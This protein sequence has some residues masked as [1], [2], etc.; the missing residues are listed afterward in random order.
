MNRIGWGVSPKYLDF[1]AVTSLA[2]I[3]FLN[4]LSFIVFLAYLNIG[5]VRELFHNNEAS[6]STSVLIAL[7]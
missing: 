5:P 4:C 3:E 6:E 7:S 1:Y 2:G